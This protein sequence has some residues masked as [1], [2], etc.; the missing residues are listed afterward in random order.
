[1]TA[2]IPISKSEFAVVDI[3]DLPLVLDYSPTW[4]RDSDYAYAT[5]RRN[6]L[7]M[8]RVIL[9]PPKGLDVDHV[10]GDK[11]DNRRSNLR[12]ATRSENCANKKIRSDNKTGFK[13][14][15]WISTKN[16]FV[17]EVEKQ[18]VKK[19]VGAFKCKYDAATAYNFAAFEIFGVFAKTN[20]VQQPW[21][22]EVDM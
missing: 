6:P 18:G 20:Y 16:R 1:M 11:F 3:D 12:L 21:L 22:E 2:Y 15:F 13:G 4:C 8:H 17:V 14:V 10:N 5:N 9:N 7:A 19:Y